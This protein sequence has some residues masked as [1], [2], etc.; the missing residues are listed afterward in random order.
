MMQGEEKSHEIVTEAM[1]LIYLLTL[2]PSIPQP[3]SVIDKNV[4]ELK[5]SLVAHSDL[6]PI[7]VH[8]I[9]QPLSVDSSKRGG[10][11]CKGDDG[12]V[13]IGE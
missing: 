7:M 11:T 3:D 1:K 6:M 8:L 9:E 12:F 2:P 5:N 13:L 4:T 10:I